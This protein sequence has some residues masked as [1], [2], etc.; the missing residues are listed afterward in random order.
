MVTLRM[1]PAIPTHMRINP[2][3]GATV[4]TIVIL[5]LCLIAYLTERAAGLLTRL[6]RRGPVSV[7]ER[8]YR[9][10]ESEYSAERHFNHPVGEV[11]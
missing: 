4:S 1:I 11:H 2:M 5:R 7:G 3:I 10:H 8:K 6:W 9:S